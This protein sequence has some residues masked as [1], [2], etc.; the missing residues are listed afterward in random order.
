M[1]AVGPRCPCWFLGRRRPRNQQ[2][3]LG[4]TALKERCR[5]LGPPPRDAFPEV[6]LVPSLG[7]RV[8]LTEL[9]NHDLLEKGPNRPPGRRPE[10]AARGGGSA[11]WGPSAQG[12]PAS[13]WGGAAPGGDPI[14]CGSEGCPR[15]DDRPCP[16]QSNA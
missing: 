13:S 11:P 1:R 15:P 12:A 16:P 3:H 7:G 9:T 8:L 4:P 10:E 14:S 6:Y 2:G 5:L